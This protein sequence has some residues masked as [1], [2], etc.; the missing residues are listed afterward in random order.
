MAAENGMTKSKSGSNKW[1][2]K[3]TAFGPYGI[4]ESTAKQPGYG[5]SPLVSKAIENQ[6]DFAASYLSGRVRSA[7]SLE[8]G[9]AGYGEGTKYAQQVLARN[10]NTTMATAI[11]S[12]QV[13]INA[14]SSEVQ[15]RNNVAA[16]TLETFQADIQAQYAKSA[17]LLRDTAQ[18]AQ[19][20]KTTELMAEAN[21]RSNTAQAA[22]DLGTDPNSAS[23]A[24]N[25]IAQQY[26][27]NSERAQKFADPVAYV[28]DPTNLLDNPLAYIG[29]ALS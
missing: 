25:Q 4:L 21:A 2:R 20:V 29:S 13:D 24:L 27:I 17:D 9:L 10:G 7:G 11:P 23:Y 18:A 19:T 26:K 16:N 3:S 12:G 15:N 28:A 5:T 8:A 1:K 6:V 22:I 14:M